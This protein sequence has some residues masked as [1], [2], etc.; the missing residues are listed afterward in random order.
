MQ[1]DRP[2]ETT[3]LAV[4]EAVKDIDVSNFKMAAW[5]YEP[6][7]EP[8][9][10]ESKII[11]IREGEWGSLLLEDYR[12]KGFT[13]I[14][15]DD[16]PAVVPPVEPSVSVES[17]REEITTTGTVPQPD[18]NGCFATPADGAKFMA[19]KGIP[20]VPLSGPTDTRFKNPGKN[21]SINGKGWPD[22]ASTD[23]AQIVA[24]A[25]QFPGCNFGSVARHEVGSYYVQETDSEEPLKQYQ[26]FAGES[27]FGAKL[28]TRSSKGS[29]DWFRHTAESVALIKNIGQATGDFSLRE[30]NQ[31]CVSP[32]S[33]HASGIQYRNVRNGAPEPAPP[34]LLEWLQLQK[35]KE[36]S[37][38]EPE[39]NAAG[40]IPQ[41]HIHD[42]MKHQAGVF[43]ARG[44]NAEEIKPVLLRLVLEN[45]QGPIDEIKV[46]TMADSICSLYKAG[47]PNS[48]FILMGDRVAGTNP[49]QPAASTTSDESEQ[50]SK[51]VKVITLEQYTKMVDFSKLLH[52]LEES[53]R[54]IEI[55]PFDPTV[56]TGVAKEITDLIIEG[57]TLLPQYAYGM[58]KTII[59]DFMVGNVEMDGVDEDPTRYFAAIGETGTGKGAAWRRLMK[60]LRP[61]GATEG[62]PIKIANGVDSGAGLK[63]FFFEFPE[64]WPVLVYI[65]EIT[66][67]GNKAGEKKQP[68]ILDAIVELANGSS[69]SRILAK[70]KTRT[71]DDAYL[72]LVIC[73]PNGKVYGAAFGAREKQ[74]IFDR[75]TPEWGEPVE[76][77]DLPP[78]DPVR[79]VMLLEKLKALPYRGAEINPP[80]APGVV[81][82]ASGPQRKPKHKKVRMVMDPEAKAAEEACWKSQTEAVRKKVRFRT[83]LRLDAYTNAMSNGRTVMNKDDVDKAARTF[84]RE[85]AIRASQF[86]TPITDRVGYYSA[87]IKEIPTA[88]ANNW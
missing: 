1:K 34:K 82:G 36:E 8:V 85:L 28:V 71:K 9:S 75:M 87:L 3:V 56:M 39:R 19:S 32:G 10:D 88:C 40:L 29:H 59:G 61:D 26:A 45:C 70:Q 43:R 80:T 54:K 68:E 51:Y 55:P 58:A 76:A 72:S 31:Q 86:N 44:M 49:A 42:Y 7:A 69:I 62:I 5:Y 48:D 33:I 46:M 78:I 63:D 53:G 74:G 65:D 23:F 27:D 21:P 17:K 14:E 24:W 16:I 12:S 64:D 41:G 18:T 22:K 79:A 67:L 66:S 77:G 25:K 38:P 30:H 11:R 47:N 20:Q 15:E 81:T 2:D 60:I 35:K 73:G 50:K 13:V 83:G 6:A 84:T 37:S 52:P 4:R 57:T